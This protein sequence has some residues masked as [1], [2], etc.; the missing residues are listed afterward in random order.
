[1]NT[2]RIEIKNEKNNKHE[3]PKSKKV[4]K[5]KVKKLI[6]KS[7][8][9]PDR[10]RSHLLNQS[11][12]LSSLM[13]PLNQVGARIPDD[14]TQPS[15]TA[16]CLMRLQVPIVG[17]GLAGCSVL[18]GSL[19]ATVGGAPTLVDV[20]TT[21]AYTPAPLNLPQ[22]K[23][24]PVVSGSCPQ[25]KTTGTGK[26]ALPGA[27]PDLL[28]A[29]WDAGAGAKPYASGLRATASQG[30]VVSA[31]LYAFY[32]GTPLTMAGRVVKHAF[33]RIEAQTGSSGQQPPT[34]VNGP[35]TPPPP[36]VSAMLNSRVASD[37]P[38]QACKGQDAI[39]YL[40]T[41][42]GDRLYFNI[43]AVDG[44]YLACHNGRLTIVVD[45]A[46]VAAGGVVE[47]WYVENWEILPLTQN[48]S[49]VTPEPSLHD[50]IEMSL[51]T[52]AISEHPFLQL[53]PMKVTQGQRAGK[54]ET[55]KNGPISLPA[56]EKPQGGIIDTI[57]SAVERAIPI[58]E[59][60]LPLAGGLAALL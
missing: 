19:N 32:E 29:A 2:E 5:E 22:G 39:K 41:D 51:V 3:S 33:S 12:W 4:T 50:P 44:S 17:D 25:S 54:I 23:A 31:G 1:M 6:S 42:G 47:F 56:A 38:L 52:N 7:V 60:L 59:K 34:E 40:P 26:G 20:C 13:D 18:V 53:S 37:R 48:I 28:W 14:V 35:T 27:A 43:N 9:N 45:G 58:G 8:G 46:A 36:T 15:L 11:G 16:H 30:R 49:Y 10:L 57:L 55:M 24:G 21:N